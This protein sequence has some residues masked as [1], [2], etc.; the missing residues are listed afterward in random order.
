MG[1]ILCDIFK[2]PEKNC[3]RLSQFLKYLKHVLHFTIIKGR[4]R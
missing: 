3:I 4:K 2:T 1:I